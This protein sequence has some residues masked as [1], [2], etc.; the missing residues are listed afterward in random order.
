MVEE[1]GGRKTGV[2]WEAGAEIYTQKAEVGMCIRGW[3]CVSWV[4]IFKKR[5]V[6]GS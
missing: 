3:A 6:G 5:N 1:H 2:A 4:T